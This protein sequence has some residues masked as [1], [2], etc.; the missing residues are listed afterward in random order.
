MPFGG[1]DSERA[2]ILLRNRDAEVASKLL[3]E[4]FFAVRICSNAEQLV[5]ELERGAGFA[6]L[7]EEH[8]SR[9]EVSESVGKWV[10]A[11]PAWSDFPII[12]LTARSDEPSRKLLA[13]ALQDRY[14]NVS[15]L[16]RP[17]HPTTL[18]SL[19]RSAMRSR[20]RQY[21]ARGLLERY[22]LL[23]REVQHRTK[24][25][26]TVV[27]SIASA[28]LREGGDGG[29]ALIA[30]LRSLAKAQDIIFEEGGGGAHLE[31]VVRSVVNTF[32]SRIS[33]EGP[34]VYLKAGVAQGFALIVHELATNAAKHGALATHS[35][36]VSVRWSLNAGLE[37]PTV[38]FEWE[39]RGGPATNPPKRRGFGRVLLEKAVASSGDPP[40]FSYGASGFT[41]HITAT[42]R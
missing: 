6:V 39:E 8:A 12:I 18:A 35:G 42:C 5:A 31:H 38:S 20:R 24:N 17:F 29:D 4:S 19:A 7:S 25:L 27:L 1:P 15:F 23:A 22:E 36:S 28:S 40:R 26:L 13:I 33:I 2:L 21:D 34:S 9:P 10:L 3:A 41:Y 37:E 14:G 30:R 32:G 11:Q 16:E